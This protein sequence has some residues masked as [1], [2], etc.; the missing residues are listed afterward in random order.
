MQGSFG[1][2]DVMSIAPIAMGPCAPMQM[3]APKQHRAHSDVYLAKQQSMA[4]CAFCRD[5]LTVCG[6][7]ARSTQVRA[8]GAPFES[9]GLLQSV[10]W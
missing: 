3:V 1:V 5:S 4:H 6:A 2:C 9:S 8:D 7:P 10:M